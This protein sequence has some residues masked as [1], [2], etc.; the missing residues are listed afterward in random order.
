MSA[1]NE[2]AADSPKAV[3]D[4]CLE[5]LRA[6]RIEVLYLTHLVDDLS[7]CEGKAVA[8]TGKMALYRSLM[9][10]HETLARN[11]Q[12]A[13]LAGFGELTLRLLECTEELRVLRERIDA[14]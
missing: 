12:N 2:W 8:S 4:A 13:L 14:W 6:A 3:Q 7:R 1:R 5:G 9:T 11:A 10:T